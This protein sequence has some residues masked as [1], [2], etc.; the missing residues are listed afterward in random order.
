MTLGFFK[1]GALRGTVGLFGG[2][3]NRAL[4]WTP[5]N[6]CMCKRHRHSPWK[7]ALLSLPHILLL[8]KYVY[9]LM[10]HM[11]CIC[12]DLWSSRFKDCLYIFWLFW[13]RGCVSST[14]SSFLCCST[15]LVVIG[16]FDFVRSF[17]L[18]FLRSFFSLSLALCSLSL[19]RLSSGHIDMQKLSE[20]IKAHSLI[21]C[22]LSVLSCCDNTKVCILTATHVYIGCIYV[23]TCAIHAIWAIYYCDY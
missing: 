20:I 4:R 9:L 6:L 8:G 12:S 5:G 11:L 16:C 3:V 21:Y 22:V 7:I 18:G 23:Y 19:S 13:K 17:N 10:I 14:V 2:N 15:S 1:R